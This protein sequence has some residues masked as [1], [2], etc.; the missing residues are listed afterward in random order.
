MLLRI[1][2]TNAAV[3]AV[4]A[5][6]LLLTPATVSARVQLEEILVIVAGLVAILVID[7]L[8]L[9]RALA[10]L[11]RLTEAMRDVE[12]LKPGYRVPVYG[13][14]AEIGELT[15][16]F[17]EMLDRLEAERR[18]SVRRSLVAQEGE[19]RRVAQELHDE[20]GQSL[21]AIMLV[22]ERLATI[23]PE[24]LHGDL[25]SARDTARASI[26]EV[27]AISRRLRPEAL[28]DLGLPGALRALCDRLSEQNGARIVQRIE[29]RLAELDPDVELVLYRVAQESLTNAVRHAEAAHI[30]LRLGRDDGRVRLEVRDDGRGI[31]GSSPGSGIQGMRERALMI[32]GDLEIVPRLQG[33]TELR[34]AVPAT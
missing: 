14:A 2:L 19:R 12:L 4:A 26:H 22:L 7:L 29:P 6:I 1:F 28:D 3:M 13:G 32:G 24:R 21:T 17:N 20:V 10:P 5:S 8:L 31:N 23:A 34:L 30:W 33:G 18:D 27:R 9:R 16:S 25:Y 15:R 11:A